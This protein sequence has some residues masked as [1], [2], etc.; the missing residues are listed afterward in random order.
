MSLVH[1]HNL[2]MGF[3][4]VRL[5]LWGKLGYAEFHTIYKLIFKNSALVLSHNTY[6]LSA[7][8]VLD[9]VVGMYE[10]N[11]DPCL[12]GAAILERKDR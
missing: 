8:H 5:L 10:Q 3:S 9:T 11:K 7:S 6:L 4:S 2:S 12:H 1:F